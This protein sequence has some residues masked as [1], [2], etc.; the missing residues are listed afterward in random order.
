MY[1]IVIEFVLAWCSFKDGW[2]DRVVDVGW[3]IAESQCHSWSR[4]IGMVGKKME[5]AR[6]SWYLFRECI[7][8]RTRTSWNALEQKVFARFWRVLAVWKWTMT[9]L[10]RWIRFWL[11]WLRISFNNGWEFRRKMSKL[12]WESG[13]VWEILRSTTY[14]VV[15]ENG[16]IDFSL[17]KTS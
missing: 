17:L 9:F 4:I 3:N 11:V 14:W 5:F 15:S 16:G 10:I 8:I 6:V 7:S 13:N 1:C 2:E 12:K